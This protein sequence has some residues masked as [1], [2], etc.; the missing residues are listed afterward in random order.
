MAE[1][2]PPATVTEEGTV[3]KE[4]FSESVTTAPPL[5]ASLF[6]VAVHVVL[7]SAGKL[8]GLQPTEDNISGSKTITVA[9]LE[10]E[11]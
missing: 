7:E 8:E 1:V 3:R 5:G 11:L 2:S 9:V 6:K 10:V 4:L